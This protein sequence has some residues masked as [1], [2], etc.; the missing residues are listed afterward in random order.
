[1][2]IVPK[3]L[4]LQVDPQLLERIGTGVVRLALDPHD[5]I[6]GEPLRYYLLFTY[7]PE[8]LADHLPAFGN[9]ELCANRYYWFSRLVHLFKSAHGPDAGLDQQLFQLLE[10]CSSVLS[11]E[12]IQEIEGAAQ[13]G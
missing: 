10:E 2:E 3:T 6:Y 9:K 12:E 1:M 13:A 7:W 8:L 11:W 5:E 4:L